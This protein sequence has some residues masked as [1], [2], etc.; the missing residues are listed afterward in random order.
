VSLDGSVN[1]LLSSPILD[2]LGFYFHQALGALLCKHGHGAFLP[3]DA[4]GHAQ[5]A[6]QVRLTDEVR[7]AFALYCENSEDTGIH[8]EACNVPIP[9]PKG[10]P[11]Q[12][13]KV[14][15]GFACDVDRCIFCCISQDY[16]AKHVRQ[17]HGIKRP[18]QASNFFH[19]S[20]VQT[21][22]NSVNRKYFQVERELENVSLDDPWSHILPDFTSGLSLPSPIARPDTERERTPFMRFMGW[23][24][25]LSRFSTDKPNLNRILSLQQAPTSEETLGVTHL[26]ML[27]T[28]V[29]AYIRLGIKICGDHSQSFSV[30]KSLVHGKNIPS[31]RWV[32][33]PPFPPPMANLTEPVCHRSTPGGP[34]PYWTPLTENGTVEKYGAVI[35]DFFRMTLRCHKGHHSGYDIPL[36]ETQTAQ[37]DRLVESLLQGHEIQQVVDVLHEFSFSLLVPQ[38]EPKANSP[39]GWTCPVRCYLAAQAIRGDGSFIP[40]DILTQKLAKLKYFCNNCALVQAERMKGD[41][42]GGMIS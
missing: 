37:A 38:P 32:T 22:L 31:G 11:V 3:N 15:K 40:P 5:H 41:T 25:H 2:A 19:P 12:L 7:Q 29:E 17:M 27:T 30:R 14:D 20:M 4:P 42:P 8:A 23:D 24:H 33:F 16:M 36:T 35:A 34:P 6:H 26:C 13:V 10:P 9:A 1:Y 28:A 39:Q 21:V 18:L